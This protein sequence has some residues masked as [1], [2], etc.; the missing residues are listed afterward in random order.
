[1]ES[2]LALA[3]FVFVVSITPGPNNLMLAASGVG[4]GLRRT[5]PH[6]AGIWVGFLLLLVV[7]GLGLGA[8]VMEHAAAALTLK[9]AGTGY[10]LYLAWTLRASPSLDAVGTSG[11]PMSFV[12]AA[13]FQFANPKG[14]LAGITMVSAFLPSLGS[15][16]SALALLCLVACVVNLPCIWSWALLGATIRTRLHDPRWRRGFSTVMVLLTLYTAAAIW[17]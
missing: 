4:F 11:R 13:L 7:C 14:W 2:V 9:L 15:G 8:L 10:L 12:G 5:V 3:T 16:W 1:M 17:L 6:M